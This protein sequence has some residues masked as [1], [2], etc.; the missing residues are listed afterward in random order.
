[1]RHGRGIEVE[2]SHVQV[3]QA[4]IL[5]WLQEQSRATTL[6]ENNRAHRATEDRRPRRTRQADRR[7]CQQDPTGQRGNPT[8]LQDP[9]LRGLLPYSPSVMAEPYKHGACEPPGLNPCGRDR[10]E[11]RCGPFAVIQT[12]EQPRTRANTLPRDSA[13]AGI[14]APVRCC[15]RFSK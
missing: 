6:R 10:A 15:S 7:T 12:A 4:A 14:F 2:P 3:D 1:M 13:F 9:R 5:A 11:D 8:P